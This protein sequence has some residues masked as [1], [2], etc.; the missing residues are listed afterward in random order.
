[1]LKLIKPV[2]GAE[3]LEAV[4][5]VLESGWLTEGE[6][7]RRFEEAV[8]AYV[9][10]KHAIAFPNCTLAM[11]ACLKVLG[12][13]VG[14]E[15]I[16]P[17]FT[18]PATGLAVKNVG[19]TPVLVDVELDSYNMDFSQVNVA[20]KTKALM[21][22]SWGGNPVVLK[23]INGFSFFNDACEGLSPEIYAI[24]DAACSL[25]A[26]VHG[27][28]TGA[29]ADLT[30]FSFHP[31]KVVTT[32][33]GGMVTTHSMELAEKLRCLKN[34]GAEKG[35]F[36]GMGTNCKLSDIQA[37]VGVAQMRKIDSIIARRIEFAR[38]YDELLEGLDAVVAPRVEEGVR[39]VYQTYA[40][41]VKKR[42]TRDRLI[43]ELGNRGIEA[44][45]GTYALHLQPAFADAKT[46]GTLG[47]STRLYRSLLALPMCHDMTLQ[48][49][50]RV[51][52]EIRRLLE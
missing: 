44:Q 23:E 36:A 14:D 9:G 5:E 34:F 45:I 24:E 2:V 47:N 42:G 46:I 13:G 18:H 25:G 7:T 32:G 28:K 52:E 37:A 19:A 38:V 11:E 31:R 6:W 35:V 50:E 12:V 43:S 10:A 17:D 15:V 8:A 39:H 26:S 33:E 21:P 4:R 48:D 22:V 51:V 30:C 20:E 3:E 41:H 27:V 1:M 16:V 40:I 29:V 49:Q